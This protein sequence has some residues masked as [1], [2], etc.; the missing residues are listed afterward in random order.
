MQRI[1]IRPGRMS[2]LKGFFF[3]NE[4]M[5]VG[6]LMLAGVIVFSFIVLIEYL[7]SC[8]FCSTLRKTISRIQLNF[9][10]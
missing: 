10:C 9:S 4:C 5:L 6:R 3:I 7:F 2:F 1:K 8:I